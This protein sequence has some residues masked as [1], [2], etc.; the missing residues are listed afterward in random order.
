MVHIILDEGSSRVSVWDLQPEVELAVG[1]FAGKSVLAD[2]LRKY[3][4]EWSEWDRY[5]LSMRMPAS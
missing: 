3:E 5:V 1:A 4:K 2:T